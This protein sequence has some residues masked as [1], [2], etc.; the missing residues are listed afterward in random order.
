MCSSQALTSSGP[1]TTVSGVSS[2]GLGSVPRHRAGGPL[3]LGGP[4]LPV[5]SQGPP[6][7]SAASRGPAAGGGGEEGES[8][9]PEETSLHFL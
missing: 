4:M 7:S 5:R 2:A 8:G 6:G 1:S 9:A 3:A